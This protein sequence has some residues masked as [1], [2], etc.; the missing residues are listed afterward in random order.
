MIW[1][2]IIVTLFLTPLITTHEP[3]R[4]VERGLL[5]NRG[6]VEVLANDSHNCRNELPV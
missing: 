4:T 3:P 6:F 5:S 1:V 2:V